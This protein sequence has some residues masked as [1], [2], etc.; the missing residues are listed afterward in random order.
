MGF[1]DRD[2]LSAD[3]VS[4]KF[5]QQYKRRLAI[6]RSSNTQIFC[7]FGLLIVVLFII[8]YGIRNP[9]EV[10]T[11]ADFLTIN[12][13]SPAVVDHLKKN[14][15]TGN[16]ESSLPSPAVVSNSSR[17]GSI[18]QRDARTGQIFK[19]VANGKTVY[20]DEPCANSA[21]QK[22]LALHHSK[23][24][25]SP[26]KETLEFLTANRLAADKRYE[27]QMKAQFIQVQSSKAAEC[28]LLQNQIDYI[29]SMGRQPQSAATQD[30]LRQQKRDLIA[31]QNQL[32]C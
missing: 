21:S 24:I 27:Q 12:L 7:G 25:V 17:N 30:R 11:F 6:R 2:Y 1:A 18:P 9:G 14:S 23:G 3:G 5:D 29:E 16:L 13:S 31:R 22:S 4:G 8:I 32:R 19:C 10:R 15:T 28:S 26:P 20:A